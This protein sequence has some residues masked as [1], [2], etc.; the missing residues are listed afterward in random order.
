MT[1]DKHQATRVFVWQWLQQDTIHNAED[2]SV[3]PNAESECNDRDG[4]KPWRFAQHA[5]GVTQVLRQ[6][7]QKGQAGLM[8]IILMDMRAVAQRERRLPLGFF[9]RHATLDVLFG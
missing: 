6:D 4:R 5:Q 8:A 9:R 2:G 3:G 7:F 1:E